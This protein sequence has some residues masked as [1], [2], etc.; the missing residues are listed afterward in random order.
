VPLPLSADF[1]LGFLFDPE[2]GGDIFF[3]TFG[4]ISTD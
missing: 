4:W 2:D 1:L 3:Q